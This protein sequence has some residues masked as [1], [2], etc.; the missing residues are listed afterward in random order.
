MQ[1]VHKMTFFHLR[2]GSQVKTIDFLMWL[3]AM[4]F[5]TGGEVD[6]ECI[7]CERSGH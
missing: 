2:C 1:Q 4:T 3:S 5:P 7:E 6:P